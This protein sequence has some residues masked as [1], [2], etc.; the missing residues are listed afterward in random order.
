M[1]GTPTVFLKTLLWIVG[2]R[3]TVYWKPRCDQKHQ[4]YFATKPLTQ[5][6]KLYQIDS[7]NYRAVKVIQTRMSNK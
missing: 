6:T 4:L 2:H 3:L 1:K 7:H 5:F